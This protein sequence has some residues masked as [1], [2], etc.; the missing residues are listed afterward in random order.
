MLLDVTIKNFRSVKDSQ[1]I[2]FEA[3][4]DRRLE[5]DHLYKVDERL[6]V[7]PFVSIIGANG[8]GKSTVIR[9]LESLQAMVVKSESEE[10]PLQRLTSCSF[11][12]DAESR[13]EPSSFTVRMI[14]GRDEETGSPRIYT[15]TVEAD[16][17][18]VYHES[19]YVHIDRSS[20]RLFVRDLRFAEDGTI[21]HVY[22]FGKLYTG[23]KK[24]FAKKVPTNRL[25]LSEAA[26]AGSESL[27]PVYDW[28][29]SSLMLMPI[30]LSQMSEQ[31]VIKALREHEEMSSCIVEFLQNM[32]FIDIKDIRITQKE[33][34]PDRLVYVHGVEKSQY[35][36]YFSSESLGTRRITMIA[37]V[38]YQAMKQPMCIIADDFGILLHDSVLEE[39]FRKFFS[40]TAGTGSQLLTTGVETVPLLKGLLR[41]DEI[42][43]T[44]KQADG[45]SRYYSL[46]DYVIRKA[47]NPQKM[48]QHGAFG[49]YPILSACMRDHKEI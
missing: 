34:E 43:F 21:E 41:N 13:E 7:L 39:L 32:D 17:E 18:M 26:F 9:A 8:A 29:S 15:Y 28:F 45:S 40:E 49:A 31:Y 4:H 23:L 25:F 10:N 33:D 19:L 46:A 35:A 12:Y 5:A 24:R 30:G 6:R 37:A 16:A 44:T 48:Y 47:D 20:K 36:S 1:T 2:T 42:W 27:V 3:I 38:F 14:I 11:S 22:R